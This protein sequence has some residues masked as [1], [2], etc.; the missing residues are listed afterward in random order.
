LLQKLIQ[1]LFPAIDRNGNL[2]DQN[3]DIPVKFPEAFHG[4][5]PDGILTRGYQPLGPSV[6]RSR[7]QAAKIVRTVPMVIREHRVP[8]DLNAK[9]AEGLFKTFRSR[10]AGNGD[11]WHTQVLP[12]NLLSGQQSHQTAGAKEK[13][14]HRLPR[15]S[16]DCRRGGFKLR[17]ILR[18]RNRNTIRA[19]ETC[20]RFTQISRRKHTRIAKDVV[21]PNQDKVNC[22]IQPSMLKPVVQDDCFG[23]QLPHKPCCAADAVFINGNDDI[24]QVFRQQRRFITGGL[25]FRTH[26]APVADHPVP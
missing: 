19:T 8:H 15:D 14:D 24:L 26:L 7:M 13:P 11:A 20:E 10:N 2:K 1:N 3:G 23:A 16:A 17:V 9:P 12:A 4:C 25:Q 18:S 5:E 6:P 22:S 21:R